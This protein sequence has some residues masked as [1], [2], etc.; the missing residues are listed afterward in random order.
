M[1]ALK[2]SLLLFLMAF[3]V[4]ISSC[5]DDNSDPLGGGNKGQ[6]FTA[7]INGDKFSSLPQE[8]DA[9]ITRMQGITTL[10]V[11]GIDAQGRDLA[12]TISGFT[13]VG[14]YV[15][16]DPEGGISSLS[17]GALFEGDGDDSKMWTSFLGT[18]NGGKVVITDYSANKRIKGTFEFEAYNLQ[19]ESTKNITDGVFDVSVGEVTL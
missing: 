5:S 8:A 6:I 12:I 4:L 10:S 19:D 7:K 1:K 13:G 14:T 2:R 3:G 11:G 9:F 18:G 17:S 15:F 16:S